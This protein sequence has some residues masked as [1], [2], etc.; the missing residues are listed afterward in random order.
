MALREEPR[1]E[2]KLVIFWKQY[3]AAL[4][5]DID[6]LASYPGRFPSF[7]V[8]AGPYCK[9]QV[10]EGLGTSSLRH[11]FRAPSRKHGIIFV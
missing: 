8:Q 6:M 5:Q 7:A 4:T 10:A 11:Q 3:I 2:T 1:N 9:Q